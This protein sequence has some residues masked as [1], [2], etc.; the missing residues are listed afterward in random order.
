MQTKAS[1]P[2][3]SMTKKAVPPLIEAFFEFSHL[4]QLYRQ[5]WLKRG[6]PPERCESVAEHSLGV[7]I[8]AL[9]LSR[10]C[11]PELDITKVLCMALLHDFGEIYTGDLIPSDAVSA[12]EK[13]LREKQSIQQVLGKLPQGEH[14][15]DIWEEFEQG[16]TLEAQ[17]IHQIDRLEMGFQA[18]IYGLQGL[19][20]P[21]EF[22]QTTDQ[23][24]FDPRLK[25]L[26]TELLD[27]IGTSKKEPEN[28]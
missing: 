28:R 24:L 3:N 25:V 16:E 20:D 27:I 13:H 17:F 21:Q 19:I 1:N 9:W 7:A 26:F 15:L 14:Y 22:F 18:G 2:K 23:A 8:L 11:F 10:T 4:K 5:G 12:D 6:V